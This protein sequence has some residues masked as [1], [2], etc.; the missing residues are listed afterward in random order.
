MRERESTMTRMRQY[1]DES[2]T[3][4]WRE[5]EN[6]MARMRERYSTMTTMRQCDD[7]SAAIR[8]RQCDST[9]ATMRECENARVR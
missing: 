1:D 4:R 5:C 7:D 6:A 8:W 9:M 2:A 3:I